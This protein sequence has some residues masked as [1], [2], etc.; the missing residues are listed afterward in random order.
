MP[1]R[2]TSAAFSS[3]PL[4]RSSSRTRSTPRPAFISTLLPGR[5]SPSRS[6]P[7]EAGMMC[8]ISPSSHRARP[9]RGRRRAE[10]RHAG[11]QLR[12]IAARHH[13]LVDVPAGR[14]DG[15]VAERQ[16][17]D[18]LPLVEQGADSVRRRVVT[19]VPRR[20][21]VRHRHIERANRLALDVARGDFERG[22]PSVFRAAAPR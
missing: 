15:R 9:S 18:V 16:K 8:S 5:A 20:P 4:S 21:V 17:G 6:L 19:R 22:P 13:A 11:N 2:S 7:W 10:R 1:H 3:C 14:V 12:V